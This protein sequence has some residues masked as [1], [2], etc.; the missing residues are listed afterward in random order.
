[1]ATVSGLTKERM[2]EIENRCIVG[3][4]VDLAGRLILKQR[5]GVEIDAG[6][7]KGG[8]GDQGSAASAISAWPVGS[9]FM[10]AVPTNPAL[11]LNGGTWERWGVGRMPISQDPNQSDFD[12]AEEVGGTKTTTMTVDQMP[13]HKH[14]LTDPGH[15][16][17]NNTIG[18][19]LNAVDGGGLVMAR[20]G[21]STAV[22]ASSATNISMSDTGGGQPQNNMP[23]YIV[24]Y[25]WKRT[26]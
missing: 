5:D 26:A 24:C 1:M 22:T 16:H 21:L 4:A 17:V 12:N 19:Q 8:K 9:I 13:A 3:G 14:P 15:N 23:P 25:M 2:I 18:R 7:V 10:A 11:L 20:P 6:S